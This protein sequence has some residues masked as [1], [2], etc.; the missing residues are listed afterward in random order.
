MWKVN[1]LNP[2]MDQRFKLTRVAIFVSRRCYKISNVGSQW[3]FGCLGDGKIA[4]QEGVQS[5]RSHRTQG[6]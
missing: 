2:N 1:L 6:D 5:A 3:L 4:A